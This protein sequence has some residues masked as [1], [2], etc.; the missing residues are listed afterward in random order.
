MGRSIDREEVH[1]YIVEEGG[2]YLEFSDKTEEALN[3]A[4]TELMREIIETFMSF[5]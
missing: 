5:N 2:I 3:K 1:S 4:L